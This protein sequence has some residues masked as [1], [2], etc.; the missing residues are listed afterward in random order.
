MVPLSKLKRIQSDA[1]LWP[2]IESMD[3][4]GVNRLPVMKNGH[5]EGMLT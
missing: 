4:S 2:A 3:G 5:I 1:E